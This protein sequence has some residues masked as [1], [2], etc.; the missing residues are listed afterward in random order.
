[1]LIVILHYIF[2]MCFYFSFLAFGNSSYHQNFFPSFFQSCFYVLL[3]RLVD[4]E[5]KFFPNQLSAHQTALRGHCLPRE[6]PFRRKRH[7]LFCLIVAVSQTHDALFLKLQLL[8]SFF[9]NWSLFG[10][11]VLKFK[12]EQC[13]NQYVLCNGALTD[14][15]SL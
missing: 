15:L 6:G 8:D 5:K 12:K 13:F 9:Q 7:H 14:Q 10:L 1:M 4:T 3:R 2:V 11:L